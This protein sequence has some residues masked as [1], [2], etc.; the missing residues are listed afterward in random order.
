MQKVLPMY[1]KKHLAPCLWKS[2]AFPFCWGKKTVALFCLSVGTRISKT[3]ISK[4]LGPLV[5]GS[6]FALPIC[7][8]EHVGRLMSMINIGNDEP[9]LKQL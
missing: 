8:K 4:H 6:G 1:W 2:F 7:Q 3:K 5:G 9:K